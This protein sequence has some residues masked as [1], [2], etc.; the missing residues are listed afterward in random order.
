MTRIFPAFFLALGDLPRPHV[1]RL[2]AQSL[3]LTLLIMALGGCGLYV[4]VRWALHQWPSFQPFDGMITGVLIAMALVALAWLMFRG[5]AIAVITLFAD[6]I[7]AEV[8][9]RHYPGAATQAVDVSWQQNVRLAI[10]SIVR[11]IAGNMI[12]L[13]LYILL[14]ATGIGTPLLALAV[15]A[16]LLGH[17]LEAM[18]LARHPGTPRLGRAAR[19]SL[20]ALSAAAF[21]IPVA[22]LLAPMLGAAMAVHII[23][24]KKSGSDP[25]KPESR[26]P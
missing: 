9:A 26:M 11:L 16:V 13:P 15:N 7:V 24:L 17:D 25:L 12:A 23:H 6:A 10:A 22:N 19:W 1:L 21:L 8:E 18:I 2:L 20:G 3:G 4:S 5:V 14:L